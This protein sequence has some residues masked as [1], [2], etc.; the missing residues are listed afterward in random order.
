MSKL[1]EQI[2]RMVSGGDP[3]IESKIELAELEYQI[4]LAGSIT[5]MQNLINGIQSENRQFLGGEY[6]VEYPVVLTNGKIISEKLCP[7]PASYIG[8]TQDKGILNVYYIK[9]NT[10]YPI[11]YLPGNSYA[12]ASGSAFQATASYF[13]TVQSGKLIILDPCYDATNQ[14]T[15]VYVQ[16]SVNNETTTDMY[17]ALIIEKILP[18]ARLQAGIRTDMVT[19]NNPNL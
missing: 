12:N 2:L 6:T 11:R 1:A 3:A 8:L 17:G 15:S 7:L 13:Y 5:G 16:L 10:M 4:T 9:N 18:W 19:D 14:L